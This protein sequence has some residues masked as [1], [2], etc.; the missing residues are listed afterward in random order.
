MNKIQRKLL[1]HPKYLDNIN[2]WGQFQE[3]FEDTKGAIRIR[4]SKV[5]R[6]HN[7]QQKQMYKRTSNDRQNIHIKQKIV[8][9]KKL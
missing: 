6:E 9:R 7:G 4:I 1:F 2:R 8:V 3:V 5:D